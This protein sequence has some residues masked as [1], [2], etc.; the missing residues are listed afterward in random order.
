MYGTSCE[1]KRR[2]DGAEPGLGWRTNRSCRVLETINVPAFVGFVFGGE[3]KPYP[4]QTIP[5]FWHCRQM[6]FPSS[7]LTRR[8]LQVPQ[9]VRTLGLLARVLLGA[10]GRCAATGLADGLGARTS[11]FRAVGISCI[12][13]RPIHICASQVAI[14]LPVSRVWNVAYR[15]LPVN[16]EGRSVPNDFPTTENAERDFQGMFRSGSREISRDACL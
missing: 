3:S 1:L 5:P 14:G 10:T 15:L 4:S 13:R 2:D 8:I 11:A 16:D 6:G 7:H 12:L 9:P